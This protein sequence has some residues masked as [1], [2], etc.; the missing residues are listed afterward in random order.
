[1]SL[2]D[3]F[4][5]HIAQA[6]KDG[7]PVEPESHDSVTIIFS[8]IVGFT[9]ISSSLE[10][11]QVADLLGRLYTKLDA[12]CGKF[13]VFKVETIGD[14]LA[15]TN[16]VKD[17]SKDHAKRIAHFA[18]ETVAAANETPIDPSDP[19]RGFVS[20]RVGFHTG[21]VVA[22]VV[23]TRNPR[24]CLFGDCVNTASRMGK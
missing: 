1:V 20:I 12:L 15:V 5:R 23:G 16:L 17:Q 11:R 19:S 21:A 3:I 18:I 14:A 4:P 10:P 7:R 6:L 9:E 13:D 2:F 22:D 24:Y 8:D